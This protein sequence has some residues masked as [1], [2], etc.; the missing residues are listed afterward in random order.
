[1]L[2][3]CIKHCLYL[4]GSETMLWEE[5][6][7]SRIKAIQMDSLRGLL[8]IR[9]MDKAPNAR[10]RESCGMTK[11]IDEWIDEGVLRWFGHVERMEDNRIAK[12]VYIGE[13]ADIRSVGRPRKRSTGTVK[14]C[15]RK[16]SL[17]A[18]NGAG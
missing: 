16:R 11:G 2:D 14:D 15:L 7:R 9:M 1:M 4:Y 10:I 8:G 17:D 3:S 5:K 18:E 12:R 6:D 13:C